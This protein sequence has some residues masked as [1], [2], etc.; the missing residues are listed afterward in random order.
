MRGESDPRA[1][2]AKIAAECGSGF[3]PPETR[4]GQGV[5]EEPWQ[6]TAFALTVALH[7]RGVFSWPDWAATLSRHLS[8]EADDGRRYYAHWLAALEE[9]IERCQLGSASDLH[10]LQ[11]AWAEAAERTPHGQPIELTP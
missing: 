4:P 11:I 2:L 10:N 1:T 3:V 7:Q 8:H 9:M 5:F 6:A